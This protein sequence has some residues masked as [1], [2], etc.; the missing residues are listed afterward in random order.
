[1]KIKLNKILFVHRDLGLSNF[2]YN[3]KIGDV[4]SLA[5]RV[6]ST[7]PTHPLVG[8]DLWPI[9]HCHLSSVP[10]RDTGR[11]HWTPDYFSHA[12]LT[13]WRLQTFYCLSSVCVWNHR[14]LA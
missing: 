8:L 3:F 5:R 12:L 11:T 6:L 4:G 14:V 9:V 1:M 2:V 10:P 13:L 7:L